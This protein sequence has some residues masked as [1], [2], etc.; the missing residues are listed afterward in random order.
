MLRRERVR[1]A[2]REEIKALARQQMAASGTTALALNAIARALGMVPS[3]LYRYYPDRD[4]LITALIVDAFERLA[5]TLHTAD[6]SAPVTS[7]GTRLLA[8]ACAY[9]T[10]ALAHPVDFQLIFGNPI[11]GYHAPPDQ[12]GPAMQRVFAAFL[13]IIQAAHAAGH[14]R[15]V[16]NYQPTALAPCDPDEAYGRYA[17][18]VMYSGLAGWTTMHGVVTLE[19]VG[20]LRFSFS[21][22]DAFFVGQIQTYLADI[23]L[24]VTTI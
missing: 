24:A 14:L 3:A 1:E 4:A 15:P 19:L 7:H 10:W 16:S 21:D 18:P 13:D 9:R 20:Q 8:V 2:T 11:P 6:Q 12:T 5:A 23:G 17:P 22:L